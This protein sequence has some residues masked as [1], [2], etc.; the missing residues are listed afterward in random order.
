M[1]AVPSSVTALISEAVVGAGGGGSGRKHVTVSNFA[2]AVDRA[3]HLP[4]TRAEAVSLA[5]L[6]LKPQPPSL[7]P[8]A[9]AGAGAGAGADECYVEV[10]LL[11]A[12]RTGDFL[13]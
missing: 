2:R 11:E 5:K 4:L 8:E 12:I 6:M 9:G 10:A 7:E 13:S 3:T 1:R